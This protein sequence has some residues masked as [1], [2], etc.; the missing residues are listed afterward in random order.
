MND[1]EYDDYFEKIFKQLCRNREDH[2][3]VGYNES[4]G[5]YIHGKEHYKKEMKRRRMVP[6]DEAQRLAEQY[7]KNNPREKYGDLSP[8]AK[9]IIE[10]L[11]LTADKHGN[12]KLG[13]RAIEALKEIG[14]IGGYRTPDDLPKGGT[15]KHAMRK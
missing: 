5:I 6:F 11:R 1:R 7:D 3:F 12:V 8:K 10:S 15:L 14:A 4:M 9:R 13:G 2:E